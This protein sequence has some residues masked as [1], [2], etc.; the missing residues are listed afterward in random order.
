MDNAAEP[1]PF[2]VMAAANER[3]PSLHLIA[4]RHP[5]G[6]SG[7]RGGGTSGDPDVG[8]HRARDILIKKCA[9]IAAVAADHSAP[10]G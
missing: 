7:W 1:Y 3:E 8:I 2:A 9:E 4:T 10:A 6:S 5:G